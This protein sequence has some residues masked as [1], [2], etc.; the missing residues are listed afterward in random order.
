MQLI[1]LF[2]EIFLSYYI[3]S[4][5]PCLLMTYNSRLISNNVFL[6][7]QLLSQDEHCENMKKLF[8]LNYV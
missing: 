6:N 8:F 3:I 7:M 1:R 5:L 4:T 2:K